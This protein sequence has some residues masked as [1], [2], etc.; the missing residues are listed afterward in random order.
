MLAV[1]GREEGGAVAPSCRGMR[2]YRLSYLLCWR[3]CC[4]RGPNSAVCLDGTEFCPLCNRNNGEY[5]SLQRENVECLRFLSCL[6]HTGGES[7][8]GSKAAFAA[9]AFSFSGGGRH[10]ERRHS[11]DTCTAAVYIK[12]H[13]RLAVRRGPF[14]VL[15]VSY[16]V[17]V[18]VCGRTLLLG[19]GDDKQGKEMS[20]MLVVVHKAPLSVRPVFD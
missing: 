14:A 8:L 15:Y 18:F 6:E 20:S 4:L 11:Y 1:D 3:F 2:N 7:F 5:F 19:A 16:V 9:A 17:L 13:I 12:R 10:N